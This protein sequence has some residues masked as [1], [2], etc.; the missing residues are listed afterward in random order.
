[1]RF[2]RPIIWLVS[3]I[4]VVSLTRSVFELSKKQD[5]VRRSQDELARLE[6]ENRELEEALAA[7]ETPE[8]I[9]KTAREKLGLVKEGETVVVL[10]KTKEGQE[11]ISNKQI[12]NWKKWRDLFF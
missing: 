5:I 2:V 8:F 1:M 12:P 11:T 9:E 6:R 7:A 10:P 3:L 4:L